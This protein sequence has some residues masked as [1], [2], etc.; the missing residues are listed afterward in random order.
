MCFT[1]DE[2]IEAEE[3]VVAVIT[4]EISTEP[5]HRGIFFEQSRIAASKR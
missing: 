5:E 3:G 2:W 1:Y 4:C